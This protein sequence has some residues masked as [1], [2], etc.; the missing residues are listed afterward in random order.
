MADTP[1]SHP[2][3]SASSESERDLTAEVVEYGSKEQSAR[4]DDKIYAIR[5]ACDTRD[6]DALITLATSEGGFLQ[7]DLRQL[8]C[9]LPQTS[10][11][12]SHHS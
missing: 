11:M 2:A 1:N 5:L 10:L 8:A 12:S 7:D 6:I 9:M 3:K 4:N